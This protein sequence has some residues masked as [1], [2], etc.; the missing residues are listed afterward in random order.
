MT[1]QELLAQLENELEDNNENP[2]IAHWVLQH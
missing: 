1:V 2:M